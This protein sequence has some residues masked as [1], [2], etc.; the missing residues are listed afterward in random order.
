MWWI[1]FCTGMSAGINLHNHPGPKGLLW[2]GEESWL[3]DTSHKG[4]GSAAA[5]WKLV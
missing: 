5:L 3:G 1:C 4:L 2:E